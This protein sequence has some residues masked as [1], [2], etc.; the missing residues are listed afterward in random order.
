MFSRQ[1]LIGKKIG[2]LYHFLSYHFS[3]SF[4]K[5]I[6]FV[7]SFL[8]IICL[9]FAYHLFP[10]ILHFSLSFSNGR[11]FSFKLDTSFLSFWLI[12]NDVYLIIFVSYDVF[13]VYISYLCDPCTIRHRMNHCLSHLLHWFIILR[14]FTTFNSILRFRIVVLPW[15]WRCLSDTEY[16][17]IFTNE[18][19]SWN[20]RIVMHQS[21]SVILIHCHH[22]SCLARA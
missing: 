11:F 4:D 14:H 1:N 22:V 15:G 12:D 5:P 2:F 3:L 6:I 13:I 9:S 7:L 18:L 21:W 19:I 17:T 16:I 20:I 8:S 10:I